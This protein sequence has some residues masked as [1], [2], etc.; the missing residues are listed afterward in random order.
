[1]KPLH[2]DLGWKDRTVDS[3]GL[4]SPPKCACT[5]FS[6]FLGVLWHTL[7]ASN[8]LWLSLASSGDLSLP[9]SSSSY[10]FHFKPRT[11]VHVGIRMLPLYINFCRNA[12]KPFLVVLTKIQF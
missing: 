10:S 4:P 11:I 9:L 5:T 1:M 12:I 8:L 7:D 3:K 6:V 2:R